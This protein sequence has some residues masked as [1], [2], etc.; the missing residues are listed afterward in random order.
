MNFLSSS[1]RIDYYDEI[2]QAESSVD[3]GEAENEGRGEGPSTA[4]FAI[5][6][7]HLSDVS[8]ELGTSNIEGKWP[9]HCLVDHVMCVDCRECCG[10]AVQCEWWSANSC[11]WRE[12]DPQGYHQAE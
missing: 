1:Y 11:G 4:D 6:V 10:M 3:V 12:T 5:K 9:P 2:S 7:L 8:I